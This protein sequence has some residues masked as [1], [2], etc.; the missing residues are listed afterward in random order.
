MV[1]PRTRSA[2]KNVTPLV[3]VGV[4]VVVLIH[5]FRAAA[6]PPSEIAP[7]VAPAWVESIGSAQLV[8]PNGGKSSGGVAPCKLSADGDLYCPGDGGFTGGVL[9]QQ[10]P[11]SIYPEQQGLVWRAP[12]GAVGWQMVDNSG[13]LELTVEQNSVVQGAVSQSWDG[14][15]GNVT[16]NDLGFGG[17]TFTSNLAANFSTTLKEAG[18]RVCTPGNALCAPA[19]T[20]AY[21]CGAFPGGTNGP[22][23]TNVLVHV[24]L[25]IAM[26]ADRL[27]ADTTVAGTAGTADGGIWRLALVDVSTGNT[28]CGAVNDVGWD[29]PYGVERTIVCDGGVVGPGEV[30]LSFAL[31]GTGGTSRPGFNACAGF[32]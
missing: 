23:G 10:H 21:V 13:R 8:N 31:G 27:T 19:S 25:P 16:M 5:A 17:G 24:F 15:T 3:L 12:A 26:H 18:S 14:N 29:W 1:H 20:P 32:K 9:I 28:P 30:D 22:A 4:L 2:V 7:F 11:G 6:A